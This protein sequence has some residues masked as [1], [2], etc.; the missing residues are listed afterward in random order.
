MQEELYTK[1]QGLESINADL[2][3]FVYAAPHDLFAPLV[4]IEGMINLLDNKMESQDAE[5]ETIQM[6]KVSIV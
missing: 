3:N 6:I 5:K 4:N 2:N 1:N